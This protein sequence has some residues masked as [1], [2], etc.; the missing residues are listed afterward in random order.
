MRIAVVSDIH[1]N[2]TAFQAVLADLRQTAPDFVFH[3]G[4]LAQGGSHPAEIIDQIR[5]LGWPGVQGNTDEVFWTSD[6][7]H[8]LFAKQPK[9]Q[10]L[11]G[12]IEEQV[13]ANRAAVGD[14]RIA[15][16]KSL[17]RRHSYEGLT[18][19]HAS[20][21]SL[22]RSPMLEATDDELERVYGPLNSKIVVYGHIHRSYVRALPEFTVANSGS[23]SL[24]YDGDTRA[25]YLLIDGEN[26]TVRRVEYDLDKA[27]QDLMSSGLPHAEWV[28]RMLRVGQYIPPE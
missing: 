23:V 27:E 14:E 13:A 25:S 18:I 15:W 4:D 24:S 2:R 16:L 19:V 10:P 1:G 11:L 28:C 6:G 9:L 7:L 22:W 3:G 17:P 8:E 20:P 12:I 21:E 5:A 26:V